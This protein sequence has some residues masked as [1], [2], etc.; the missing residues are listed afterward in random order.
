MGSLIKHESQSQYSAV[1]VLEVRAEETLST[2]PASL[3][4]R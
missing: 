4:L 3:F 2:V 1:L